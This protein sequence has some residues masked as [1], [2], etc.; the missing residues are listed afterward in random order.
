[1]IVSIPNGCDN[2]KIIRV[3]PSAAIVR[4]EDGTESR[5]LW[6]EVAIEY[7]QP[8]PAALKDRRG[9]PAL[10]SINVRGETWPIRLARGRIICNGKEAAGWLDPSGR[11]V[12][13][14][15]CASHGQIVRGVGCA[16][17]NILEDAI[18]K[19][20]PDVPGVEER[21]VLPDPEDGQRKAA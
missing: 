1:M 11:E 19:S 20:F 13:M 5:L 14:S 6:H 8:D 21:Q 4:E 15:E 2:A 12:L 3:T 18:G 7:V 16:F 10:G 9:F 17:L